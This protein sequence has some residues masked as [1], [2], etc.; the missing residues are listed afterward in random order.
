M[1][2]SDLVSS[3]GLNR[4]TVGDLTGDLVM[5]GLVR[6]TA[7]V[8]RGVGRPSIVVAPNSLGVFV[9]AFDVGVERTLAAGVGLGGEVLARREVLRQRGEPS[10]G[11]VLRVISTLGEAIVA[12]VPQ[13]SR[14]V[15]LGVAVAGVVRHVDGLVRFA[16]NMGWRDVPFGAMLHER[17]SFGVPAVVGNDADLGALAERERGVARGSANVIFLSCDVGVGGGIILDGRPLVGAGGYGGELGHMAVNPG[18]RTCR[19]GRRGCWET[20]IG[21]AAVVAALGG[22]PG[23]S[24]DDLLARVTRAGAGQVPGLHEVGRWIGVGLANLVNLFN[25]DIIVFGGL[26][27]RVVPLTGPQ[28][29]AGLLMALEAPRQQVRIAVSSLGRDAVVMGAAEAA[30]APL[31]DDPLGAP[32]F[33]RRPNGGDPAQRTTRPE[34]SGQTMRS[35]TRSGT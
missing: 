17:L 16:P 11:D 35:T 24:V 12:E 29:H 19:C 18:G 27:G 4:S 7:P 34:S 20:E 2:R 9:L 23:D 25:P 26:L 1:S 28:V 10:P 5:A 8:G 22:A 6:E 31:L 21:E 3:T 33:A 15:G 32:A 30:F 14:C 13:H